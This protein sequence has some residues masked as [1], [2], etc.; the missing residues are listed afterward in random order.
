[1]G[2]VPDQT[3]IANLPLSKDEL[4]GL[5]DYLDRPNPDPCTHTFK[6]TEQYLAKTGLDKNTIIPWLQEHGAGCDCEVIFNVDAD[7]GE[8]VGR[9]YEDEDEDEEE[10]ESPPTQPEKKK[11]WWQFWK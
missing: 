3:D 10:I 2:I 11:N 5:F 6:E 8:I 9:T 7:W 4:K 1:M